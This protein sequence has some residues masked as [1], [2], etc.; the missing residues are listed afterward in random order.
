MRNLFNFIAKLFFVLVASIFSNASIHAQNYPENVDIRVTLDTELPEVIKINGAFAVQ[1]Q[2]SLDEN[3]SSIPSG[4]TVRARV[5]LLDPDNITIDSYEQLWTEGFSAPTDGRLHPNPA[6]HPGKVLF[7]IPW[8]QADKW[9]NDAEWKILIQVFAPSVETD[10]SDNIIERKFTIVVPDLVPTIE[11]ISAVDPLSGELSTAYVPNTNYQVS[12]RVTNVGQVSTQPG[13]YIP[14]QAR[15]LSENGSVLDEEIILLG[16]SNQFNYIEANG[17]A[18]EFTVDELFVPPTETGALS[19][20]LAV[21]PNTLPGGPV[22]IEQDYNNN[23]VTQGVDLNI[24][25]EE[26]VNQ[27]SKLL[28]VPNSY[29]GERGTFRGMDP[30][31]ISFAVRNSGRAPVGPTDYAKASIFLSKDLV[32]DKGDFVIREFNLSGDGIGLGL[33]AGDTINLTWNQQL[34]D[35][36]E[37]D[38]YLLIQIENGFYENK[39]TTYE[40]LKVLTIETTQL[41]TTPVFTLLSENQGETELLMTDLGQSG[42]NLNQLT[43]QARGIEQQKISILQQKALFPELGYAYDQQIIALDEEINEVIAQINALASPAERPDVSKDGRFL[44]FEKKSPIVEGEST[45]F[46]SQQIYLLDMMQPNLPPVL[47]TRRYGTNAN[48][49][50]SNGNSFRPRI[51]YDGDTVVFHSIANDLVPGDTNNKE[52]VFVYRISTQTMFRAV[53]SNNEQFNGRSLY[54]VVNGDGTKIVFESDATNADLNY[55]DGGSQIYLWT[56]DQ[57]SSGS[58]YVRALTK[59]DGESYNPSID[60]KGERVVFHSYAT[61]L[62]GSS[63]D[64]NE[65]SDIFLIQLNSN[66]TYSGSDYFFVDDYID[67]NGQSLKQATFLVNR[68]YKAEQATGGHSSSAKISGNGDRIVFESKATNLVTGAGI[69]LVEVIEGGGGYQGNPKIEIF[70]TPGDFNGS[71][72]PGTGAELAL[73]SDGINELQEIDTDAIIVIDPG[74]GYVSPQVRIIPD[75]DYPEPTLAAKAVAYLGSPEGDIYYVNVADLNGSNTQP[76]DSLFSHRI[77]QSSESSGGNFG[78]RDASIDWSG[79]TILYSTKSSNL[80]KSSIRRDDGIDF[81]N[82]PFVLPKA[83]ALLVGGI[84]EIEISSYGIGYEP[85]SLFIEDLSGSGSGAIASYEVDNLGRIVT[86]N[87]IDPGENYNLDSTV[88]SVIEPR[89]GTGFEVGT[90]RFPQTIGE[91]A[92]RQGGG[93]IFSVKIEEHGKGYFIGESDDIFSDIIQFEGDGADLNQDGFPDGRLNPERLKNIDGSLYLEQRFDVDVLSNGSDLANTTL[94]IS[95]KNNSNDPLIIRFGTGTDYIPISGKSK[96]DIR[97]L[98]IQKI[99]DELEVASGSTDVETS[100]V[101]D[102]NLSGGTSFVF[103]AL[104]GSFISSNPSA[105]KVSMHS[106]MLIMGSG[107]STVTPVINQVP[108]IFG[109]SEVLSNPQFQLDEEVGRMTLLSATD[110]QSDDIYKYDVETAQNERVSTSSFG[111]PVKYLQNPVDSAYPSPASNRFPVISG[112]GRY[113]F[114]SSDTWGNE[115][116]AFITSNQ[117]PQDFNP[118]RDLYLR[119]LKTTTI[120]EDDVVSSVNILYPNNGLS[121]SFSSGSSIPIVSDVE[122]SGVV[123]RLAVFVNQEFIADME[124]FGGGLGGTYRSSRYSYELNG[125]NAGEYS[126]QLVAYGLDGQVLATSA[127]IRFEVSSYEGSLPPVITM[128]NPSSFSAITSTSVIPISSDAEDPD[129]TIS[130]VSY[131]VDGQLIKKINRFAGVSETDQSFAMLLDINQTLADDQ[132]QGF[133][134]IFAI[135]ED[136]SGN[137]VSS[138]IHNLSFTKG[139]TPP[140][141]Q[142][143]RGFNGFRLTAPADLNIT[144]DAATLG[145]TK[146]ELV[147]GPVGANLIDAK[148]IVA[149]TGSGA[150]ILPVIDLNV[151]S[152]TYGMLTGF[153]IPEGKEGAG[154]NSTDIEFSVIPVL[155]VINEGVPA[156]AFFSSSPPADQNATTFPAGATLS[157]YVDGSLKAGSGY[158]ISPRL[159]T[160][161]YVFNGLQRVPLI[162]TTNPTSSLQDFSVSVDVPVDGGGRSGLFGGFT[163]APIIISVEAIP[164][165][166]LIESVYLVI[167]GVRDPELVKTFPDSNNT[168]NFTWLPEDPGEHSVSA[169][170]RDFAGNII[171]TQESTF[172]I[173][174]YLGSGVNINIGE[175]F[176]YEIE[177]NGKLFLQVDA[178]SE[179]D[180]LEV[181]F[182]IDNQLV[183]KQVSNGTDSFQYALDLA[184]PSFNFRQGEHEITFIAYDSRGNTAGTF[185]RTLTNLQSRKNPILNILPPL[186]KNK[187]GVSLVYPGEEIILNQGSSIR[188]SADANDSNGDLHGVQFYH[189]GSPMDAWSGKLDFDNK[190]PVDGQTLRVGLSR[191]VY[192]L[193]WQCGYGISFCRSG[194]SGWNDRRGKFLW[195]RGIDRE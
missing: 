118:A 173:Q 31:F 23:S 5:E 179:Y 76:N 78:S 175:T 123:G 81:Y 109:F 152:P 122:Y 72:A 27:R 43:A 60:D 55:P 14:V 147:S 95:D 105:I 75:P 7:Q 103:R 106:N 165:D 149:G 42:D 150:E 164:S 168:Y 124:E 2:V 26:N 195:Q 44:V 32:V 125:L 172:S 88:V 101:I 29:V 131:Y 28:F 132:T 160:F 1:A 54:P 126:L 140:S 40:E 128:A 41:D 51:S 100:P 10:L 13:V 74:T 64:T 4:E 115:G 120:V 135:A 174:N 194:G 11:S 133:R 137:F 53:N 186:V 151:D 136:S 138:Q 80:L 66:D 22:Q 71:G 63:I 57:N 193:F 69:A 98:I 50:A 16:G 3:S 116:L 97:R 182:F 157:K 163:Q 84:G 77:S 19:L 85:G 39:N 191:R 188:L 108:S 58:G 52:D 36:Y 67:S 17:G 178:T 177:G 107:Y 161:G 110:Y 21:N 154:Y 146:V 89:G 192:G 139:S 169:A 38:F 18:W 167:N 112:N 171:S 158:V 183:G 181:D 30:A 20:S 127:L 142:V 82:S 190:V 114:F 65:H 91:G 70:D 143:T 47:I 24:D 25:N 46:P 62:L 104:S 86:I 153:D 8:S 96:S 93:R 159:V 48:P 56:L 6:T 144:R 185:S 189:A 49:E 113:V 111:T 155:R 87:V 35:N 12:G 162:E 15:L 184:D 145:I 9:T 83:S 176:D 45:S 73:K 130:S 141:I 59:G 79:S 61:N 33:L 121:H 170:V 129:G 117:F 68:S 99:V 102:G 156:E 187:P 134:T 37:G 94:T 34:P 92:T 148:V 119:D 90:I 180:V 166:E